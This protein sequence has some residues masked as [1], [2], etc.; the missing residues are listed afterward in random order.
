M[1]PKEKLS[2]DIA[3]ARAARRATLAA[4]PAHTA[5][6]SAAAAERA[7]LAAARTAYSADLAVARAARKANLDAVARTARKAN[8]DAAKDAH[9]ITLA[10][11]YAKY[12]ATKATP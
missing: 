5:F 10:A 8:L 1:N 7:H 3:A 12:A 6:R 4:D 2:A 11:A 9:I